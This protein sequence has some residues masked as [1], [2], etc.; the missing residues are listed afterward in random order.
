MDR[1]G[2]M[3]DMRTYIHW[4]A[5]PKNGALEHQVAERK[6]HE[7][8]QAPGAIIDFKGP[9]ERLRQRVW[10]HKKGKIVFRDQDRVSRG[11]VLKA[12]GKSM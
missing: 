7:L 5:K 8:C 3:M 10:V 4:M 1:E 2:D 11:A 6:W 9:E 12:C